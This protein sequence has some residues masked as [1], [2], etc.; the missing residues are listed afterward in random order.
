MSRTLFWEEQVPGNTQLV[1]AIVGSESISGIK[2]YEIQSRVTTILET[3][4]ETRTWSVRRRY[5]EFRALHKILN[6][7]GFPC[8]SLPPKQLWG[9]HTNAFM[10]NRQN[11]LNCWTKGVVIIWQSCAPSRPRAAF[12]I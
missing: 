1:A 6:H 12:A 8:P 11:A 5:S 10:A 9:G 2:F 4:T 3:G 7:L